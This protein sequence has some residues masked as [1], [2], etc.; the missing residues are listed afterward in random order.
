MSCGEQLSGETLAFWMFHRC[1]PPAAL[2]HERRRLLDVLRRR[3]ILCE[4]CDCPVARCLP[5]A[6]PCCPDCRCGESLI[7]C[8]HDWCGRLFGEEIC[9]MCGV[10]RGDLQWVA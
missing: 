8:E 2:E 9:L 3:P 10:T 5:R 1:P 7:E 4:G 6:R